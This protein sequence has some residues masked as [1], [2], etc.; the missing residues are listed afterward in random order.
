MPDPYFMSHEELTSALL[1]AGF[2]RVRENVF[3]TPRG[4][5]LRL[6]RA[7]GHPEAYV[8]TLEE[9]AGVSIRALPVPEIEPAADVGQRV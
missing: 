9:Y 5:I 4:H 2:V 6:R 8:R 3:Q 7:D 1:A